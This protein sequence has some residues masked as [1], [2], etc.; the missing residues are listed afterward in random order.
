MKKI[1]SFTLIIT[2]L[3][4]LLSV[5]YFLF[6]KSNITKETKFLLGTI[7]EI[8]VVHEDKNLREKSIEAAYSAVSN[9]GKEMSIFDE[10]SVLSKINREAF[11]KAVSLT[12]NIAFVLEQSLYFSKFSNGAFDVTAKKLSDLWGF[13]S[14]KEYVPAE[15][16]IK[17][18]LTEVGYKNILISDDGENKKVSFA[19]NG[20]ELD[21]GGIAKGYACDLAV[22][23]LK[24]FGIE[25]AM[26]NIGGN[27]FAL[28]NAPG[29]N[30]WQIA[31]RN[32]RDA[33]KFAGIV[34]LK[35]QAVST[36][37]DYEQFFLRGEARYSHIIDPTTGFPVKG[38]VAVSVISES[39]MVS[40]AL[41]TAFFVLGLNDTEKIVSKMN[42]VE[43]LFY[44]EK[45]GE[46][47]DWASANFDMQKEY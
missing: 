41:S 4:V 8:T 16:E 30:G 20:I 9:I 5:F 7:C 17:K 43:V 36:S 3:I 37:G 12:P 18:V 32:P 33:E 6:N 23:K 25:N 10:N 44:Y 21:F 28:G 14:G 15:D 1:N 26:V 38:S 2:C 31:V 35:N 34:R 42:S 29:K 11:S 27:I 45:D 39:A 47:N 46:M 22:Q 40:D 13:T 24:E 19:V